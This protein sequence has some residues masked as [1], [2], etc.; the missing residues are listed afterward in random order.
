MH[1]LN[2]QIRHLV[3]GREK[4][5]HHA[6]GLLPGRSSC[7]A[8]AA[9]IMA[10]VPSPNSA[11]RALMPSTPPIVPGQAPQ[12]LPRSPQLNPCCWSAALLA[13]GRPQWQRGGPTVRWMR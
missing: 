4:P 13:P 1:A 6:A 8:A 3:P 12:W 9:G 7:A 11:C 5:S 10:L 2:Q